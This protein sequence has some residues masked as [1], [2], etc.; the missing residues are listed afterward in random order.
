MTGIRIRPIEPRDHDRLRAFYA[1]LSEESR[2]TRFFA[3]TG[4]IGDRQS[5]WFCTPDHTHREGLVAVTRHGLR[6]R[7]VGHV[8]IEPIDERTAEI[9]VAVDDAFQGRGIG[10]RLAIAAADAARSDGYTRLVATMLAGNPAIQRLLHGLGLPTTS[11][12]IGAGVVRATIEL[13]EARQAA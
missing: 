13:G 6:E 10:R 3:P 5:A 8:C 12:P 4:G 11:C 9:A 1:G 7:I 2:R